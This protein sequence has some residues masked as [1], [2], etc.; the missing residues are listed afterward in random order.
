[1]GE[2]FLVRDAGA[3]RSIALKRIRPD[4]KENKTIQSRFLREAKVAS[5][6][7]HPSIIPILAIV[8]APV[9]YYTMPYVEVKHFARFSA[10]QK[11]K[12][13]MEKSSTE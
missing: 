2:V 13:K 5:S 7:T 11:L 10:K 3:D 9:I 1:M 6:L 4:L 12:K 8:D